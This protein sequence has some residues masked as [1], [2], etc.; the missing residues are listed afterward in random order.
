MFQFTD[1][2]ARRYGITDQFDPNQEAVGA[3]HYLSDLL[4]EF[5][6][7]VAEAAAGYNWGEGNVEKALKEYGADWLSHAPLETQKYVQK[8]ESGVARA[9]FTRTHTSRRT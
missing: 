2:T 7:N 3:S 1:A 4:R 8:V 9:S 5:H 6:G